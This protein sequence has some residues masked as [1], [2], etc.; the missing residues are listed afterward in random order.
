M[1]DVER[2][3]DVAIVRWR[4][5]ENRFNRRSVARWHE[6]LDELEA[7]DDPLAVVITGEGRFFSNG[8]DLDAFGADPE[9]GKVTVPE[10]HRLFGRLLVFPAYV[11]AALNGHTFAGGAMLACCA[12]ERVMRSDRG[13]WC[14]PEADLGLPVTEPMMATVTARLSVQTAAEALNTGRR[15]TAEEALAA[16]IVDHVAPEAEV[17]PRAIERAALV[18]AKSRTVIATH[19]AMLFSAAAR[20]CGHLT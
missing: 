8:L 6:V 10:V 2:Q 1:I 15:Y 14:L 17:L 7:T 3:G 9:E 18:A 11:V 12:D 13:Y 16:G 5:G 20:T 4:D 19:K